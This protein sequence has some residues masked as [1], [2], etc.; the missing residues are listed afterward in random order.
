MDK[1]V[2]YL[3]LLKKRTEKNLMNKDSEKLEEVI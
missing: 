3:K 2:I 1:K